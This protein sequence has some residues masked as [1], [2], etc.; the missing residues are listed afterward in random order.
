MRT[1]VK[2]AGDF[3]KKATPYVYLFPTVTLMVVLIVVPITMVI[4]YSFFDNVIVNPSPEFVGLQ[5]YFSILGDSTFRV[6]V[7]NT[8]FFVG[9]S[10]LFHMILG[11]TFAMLLN[12][13]YIGNKT[14]AV[15][16]VLYVLP[17]VFTASVIAILWRL[18]L[19][20][21]GIVNYILNT[22]HLVDGRIEW[23]GSRQ[24]ALMSVTVVN[25]WAGYPFFMISILAGLQGISTDLYEAS[26]IDGA[27]MVQQFLRIT[28]PQLKPIL[29]SL[30]M[31][32]FVWTTQQ[33]AL[34]WMLTGGGPINATEMLSTYIYKQGFSRFQYS[35]ASASATIV[36]VICTIVAI[37]YVRHQKARD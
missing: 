9:F 1:N 3:R 19:N 28:I 23:L 12:T 6:A 35:M 33:F 8:A 5:N 18:M 36:L 20:P 25:I 7:R 13:R 15:F 34:I 10:V 24:F 37:L 27:N 4:G 29:I 11:M 14:K 22:L 16:R 2:Y 26:A 31:L 30:I 21:S 32:D 17:W